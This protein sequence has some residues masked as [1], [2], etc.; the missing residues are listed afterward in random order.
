M[1][2]LNKF[3]SMKVWKQIVSS[4]ILF[5]FHFM[6]SAV[7]GCPGAITRLKDSVKKINPPKYI[8]KVITSI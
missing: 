5:S 2:E 6:F 4:C 7:S 3:I 1:I 8:K